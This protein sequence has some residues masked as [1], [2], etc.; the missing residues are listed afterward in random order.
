M[1]ALTKHSDEEVKDDFY[2]QLENIVDQG[3]KHDI[4]LVKGDFNA[5]TGREYKFRDY[6]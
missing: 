3:H 1:C 5:I 2:D 4:K 6:S